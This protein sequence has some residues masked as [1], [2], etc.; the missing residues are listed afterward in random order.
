MAYEE[1]G[2]LPDA[3]R[4]IIASLRMA[5]ADLDMRN[6]KAIICAELGDL[7]C[8]H[9]EWALL[10][11]V[12]PNYAPAQRNLAILMG[13]VP[14]LPSSPLNTVETPPLVSSESLTKAFPLQ[15]R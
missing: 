8:A 7:K 13:S 6:T 15:N 9:D 14:A 1:A 10:L 3:M 5:P 12:A 4:E 2:R 11:Q